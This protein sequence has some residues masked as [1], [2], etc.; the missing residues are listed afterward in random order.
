MKKFKVPKTRVCKDCNKRKK[1]T[2]FYNQSPPLKFRPNYRH[3]CKA[4]HYKKVR[5][6]RFKSTTKEQRQVYMR[7]YMKEYRKAA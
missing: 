7:T 3:D 2:K 6:A 1:I 4:C 5:R